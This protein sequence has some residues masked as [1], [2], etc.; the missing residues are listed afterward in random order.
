[1]KIDLVKIRALAS[2]APDI[3]NK[4]QQVIAT[5]QTITS[6]LKRN[7][8]S[9]NSQLLSKNESN[10]DS[11]FNQIQEKDADIIQ[12]SENQKSGDPKHSIVNAVALLAPTDVVT[13]INNM[14]SQASA[15]IRY[16][17]EQETVRTDIRA[18]AAVE[19]S[20]INTMAGMVRDYLNRSFDERAG[21]FDN[22]FS[23]LDKA[24][25]RGDNTLVAQTLQSIN[26]LAASSPFKDIAD[27]NKFSSML[28]E[29]DEWDI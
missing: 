21:L 29:E 24:L 10:D 15:T 22:Y 16:C 28:I 14:V 18:K 13:A 4:G 12:Y 6:S 5:A 3:I 17:E 19:I 2:Q 26:S 7:D 11:E 1:M 23:I 20:K 27:M 9:E 25:E 8:S